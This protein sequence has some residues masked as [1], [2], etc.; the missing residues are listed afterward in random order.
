VNVPTGEIS[1]RL[2]SDLGGHPMPLLFADVS[3]SDIAAGARPDLHS[4]VSGR[5]VYDYL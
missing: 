5:S 1:F 3:S 4:R 2:V